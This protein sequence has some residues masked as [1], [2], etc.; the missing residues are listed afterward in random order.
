MDVQIPYLDALELAQNPE[1]RCSCILILDTSGSMAGEAIEELNNGVQ[2]FASELAEDPLANRR[3]EVA[4]VTFG[5]KVELASN[6]TSPRNFLPT[7]FE[8]GGSTP[9]GEAV[10]RAH[11]LLE[12]RK[13]SYREAGIQYFRPWMFLVTD[14]AP[15]DLD[16]PYWTE[17]VD[18]V[19]LGESQR[20]LLFFG[21]G[22]DG[23]DQRTLNRLCPPNR[24]SQKLRGLSF[25]EMF[26]WLTRTLKAVS[27]TSPGDRI[28][29]P[30]P[31]AWTSIDV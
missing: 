26:L 12:A 23:A 7:R 15:T 10:V 29:L 18:I 30:S 6:F 4:V 21:V 24:P 19:H 28:Q 25:R 27:C 11:E 31:S 22:V 20:R 2:L 5:N 13:Q 1:P 9:M 17:A 8:A 16:S 14:G 3:V